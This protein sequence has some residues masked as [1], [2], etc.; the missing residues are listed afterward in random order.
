MKIECTVEEFEKLIKKET[1]VGETTDAENELIKEL[2]KF[3]KF[4]H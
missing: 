4:N 1:P 3:E 2:E